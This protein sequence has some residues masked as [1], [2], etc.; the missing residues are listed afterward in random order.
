[1]DHCTNCVWCDNHCSDNYCSYQDL[2]SNS[3]MSSV[4]VYIYNLIDLCYIYIG[5]ERISKV[6]E[7]SGGY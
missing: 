5:E 3:S 4:D 2:L 6:Y 1:M 7:G